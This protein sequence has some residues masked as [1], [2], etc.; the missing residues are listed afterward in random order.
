MTGLQERFESTG[1]HHVPGALDD[2][3]R[4]AVRGAWDDAWSRDRCGPEADAWAVLLA[5]G[6]TV[7]SGCDPLTRLSPGPILRM[8]GDRAVLGIVRSLVGEDAVPSVVWSLEKH[9]GDGNA[10]RWHQ[11]AVY[12]RIYRVVT[13][14]YHIDATAPSE[15]LHVLPGSQCAAQD[16]DRVEDT[17]RQGTAAVATIESEA[18]DVLVHDAM[19]VHGSAPRAEPGSRLTIYVEYRPAAYVLAR[20]PGTEAWV[21]ARQALLALAEELARTGREPAPEDRVTIDRAITID[22]RPEG[23]NQSFKGSAAPYPSFSRSA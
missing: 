10:M 17:I 4:H 2:R 14:G 23:R 6:Q 22:R 5:A 7:P 21:D 9:A 18:G 1:Y 13:V 12:D 16:M 20:E 3:T 8:I 19:L 11:D 15:R